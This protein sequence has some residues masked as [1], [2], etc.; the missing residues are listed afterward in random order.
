MSKLNLD[1]KYKQKLRTKIILIHMIYKSIFNI[2]I[3]K[4]KVHITSNGLNPLEVDNLQTEEEK[5]PPKRLP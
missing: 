4:Q 1:K 3:N 2:K 5:L